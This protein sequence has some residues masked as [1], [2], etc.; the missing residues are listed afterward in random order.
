MPE[1]KL[2]LGAGGG[3]GKGGK[4]GGRSSRTPVEADDTLSSEQFASILDLLCEGEI[5]GLDD[6]GRS[7]FLDNTPLQNADGSFN[8]D[9]FAVAGNNGTQDQSPIEDATG[10]VQVEVPV[11]IEVT[12]DSPITRTITN[13]NV[14]QVRVTITIP[15]LQQVTD[16]GDIV[17]HSVKIRVQVQYNGGGYETVFTDKISG[18]SSSA[19]RHPASRLHRLS[20]PA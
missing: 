16:K 1:E 12:K 2:I 19:Y 3:G 7:I 14:D 20:L 8:F 17:G 13:T 18:K 11:G 6:G 9:D 5:E 10:G 15:S 4:G